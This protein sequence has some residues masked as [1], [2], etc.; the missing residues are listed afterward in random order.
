MSALLIT[1]LIWSAIS[2]RS[3]D[4]SI[5]ETT[6]DTIEQESNCSTLKAS[7]WTLASLVLLIGSSKLLVHGAVNIA[8]ALGVSELIIG[9]TIIAI[10]TS[11][12]ELAASVAAVRQKASSMIIG[13]IIGSNTFNTLGVL[14][15]TGLVRQTSVDASVIQRDFI[16]LFLLMAALL[17][18][19]YKNR[20]LD[21]WQGGALLTAY[22]AYLVYLLISSFS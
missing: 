6:G 1:Y 2:N 8:T 17:F 13:N 16:V 10:G 5:N 19:V 7:L 22:F 3:E 15:L 11:L 20:Q 4:P 14:G 21:R 12:P 18:F 9:L